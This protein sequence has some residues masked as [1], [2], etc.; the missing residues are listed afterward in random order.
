MVKLVKN[1]KV[2]IVEDEAKYAHPLRD[3]LVASEKG[4]FEVVALTNSSVEAWEIIKDNEPDA[5]IIDLQ[6]ETGGGINLLGK[7]REHADD[8]AFVPYTIAITKL[9]SVKLIEAAISLA[10]Y[11]YK[12][13]EGFVA[14]FVVEHLELM[15]KGFG[16]SVRAE[17]DKVRL[18]L[19]EDRRDLATAEET[20]L[21]VNLM[22]K[23]IGRELDKYYI[24]HSGRGRVYLME[25]IC[26]V[27]AIP[28]RD[29]VKMIDIYGHI[30]EIFGVEIKS[31][32][33]TIRRTIQKTYDA[34]GEYMRAKYGSSVQAKI[35][36]RKIPTNKDFI[37]KI[38]N[39]IRSEKLYY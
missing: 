1:Y 31:I 8:L 27:I 39:K 23:R 4:K 32:D 9:S 18:E 12:K 37:T 36:D 34:G 16:K 28:S 26:L 10:D 7:I 14:G 29:I 3:A 38:A 17:M 21:A 6:L 2:L 20:K 13:N 22:R 15:A 11:F 30:A 5:V 33:H 25:V 35:I 19:E 24:S